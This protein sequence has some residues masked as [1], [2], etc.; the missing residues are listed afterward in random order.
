[1]RDPMRRQLPKLVFAFVL[2]G[3]GSVLVAEQLNVAGAEMVHFWF[4]PLALLALG[5]SLLIQGG[6]GALFGVGLLILST[7]AT[8]DRLGVVQNLDAGDAIG[9]MLL[10]L[11]G[12]LIL[13]RAFG[14][15]WSVERSEEDDTVHSVAIMAGHEL[16]CDAPAF[17]GGSLTAIMG[18]CELDLTGATPVSGGADLDLL[19]VWGGIEIR[20][21][22]EWK[23]VSHVTPLLGG[24]EDSREVV[25]GDSNAPRLTL[26]GVA[27]MGGIEITT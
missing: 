10:I 26:R 25:A 11:F 4:F 2:I 12:G 24:F 5:L 23:V 27:V 22:S 19:A 9:P 16:R 15:R 18:G 8:I 13:W 17:R 1:M 3:F 21:P 6:F 7:I 20:V 14:G